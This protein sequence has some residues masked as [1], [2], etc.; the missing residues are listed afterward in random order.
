MAV[1]EQTTARPE[2]ADAALKACFQPLNKAGF[3]NIQPNPQMLSVRAEKRVRGQWTRGSILVQ[4]SR[5]A[6][7]T[8]ITVRAEATAQSLVS[9]ANKPSDRLVAGFLSELDS[10]PHGEPPPPLAPPT[11]PA[12]AAPSAAPDR[13]EQLERLHELYKAGALTQAESTRRRPS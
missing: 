7:G 4:L 11:P 5:Q 10:I 12:T 9:A 6:G 13:L 3:K 1:T 8:E 2:G